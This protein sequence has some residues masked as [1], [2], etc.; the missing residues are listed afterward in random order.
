MIAAM[1]REE[2][3]ADGLLQSKPPGGLLQSVRASGST[4]GASLS[5]P[6]K[7][8]A[9]IGA[10]QAPATAAPAASSSYASAL[11]EEQRIEDAARLLQRFLRR[12]K[13]NASWAALMKM[14]PQ[15][16]ESYLDEAAISAGAGSNPL[17]S[18]V[19]LAAREQLRTNPSVVAALDELWDSCVP[20]GG[21][22]MERSLYYTM[23]RKLYL[24]A[25]VEDAEDAGEVDVSLI[26]AG[27]CMSTT[28]ADWLDDSGG[29]AHL[30][31]EDFHRCI[32]QLVDMQ[33]KSIH[34][35]EYVGWIRM[36]MGRIR[37]CEV[38]RVDVGA[39]SEAAPGADEV[40]VW[41]W[42]DDQQL[43]DALKGLNVP[44]K[45]QAELGK[46]MAAWQSAFARD[47]KR[48]RHA[49]EAALR[50]AADVLRRQRGGLEAAADE[51]AAV[52]V[53]DPVEEAEQPPPR[54][55]EGPAPPDAPTRPR[56][57][58]PPP[59]RAPAASPPRDADE[60]R[61][62]A[63]PAVPSPTA[64]RRSPKP[65]GVVRIS[66]NL[67]HSPLSSPH[68]LPISPELTESPTNFP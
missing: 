37:R 46:R 67:R 51:A 29:K 64:A 45:A 52:P 31:R 17:Y 33:T 28:D 41:G 60:P 2:K 48:E 27:E 19:A 63:A 68:L 39:G 23:S 21:T 7:L 18:N 5:G 13:E 24:A 22:L 56:R 65:G 8:R 44:K 36:T 61:A 38:R 3:P 15:L 6:D 35:E 12:R 62:S 32:F 55:A 40:R 54:L 9:R 14:L 47:Q 25:V 11:D 66:P 49:H 59:R 26:D 10:S 57:A 42:C 30:T 4:S 58:N 43:L 1:R 53:E 50:Q 16:R 34:C 20:F